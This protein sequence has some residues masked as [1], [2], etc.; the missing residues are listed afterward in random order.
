MRKFFKAAKTKVQNV[1]AKV[2]A[3]LAVAGVSVQ[4]QAAGGL[5]KVNT[6]LDNILGVLNGASIAVVTIA[7]IWAGYKFLF[8]NAEKEEI[9][10]IVS[11]GLLIGGAG[12][13][14][15]FLLG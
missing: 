1:S 5:E 9:I 15:V 12:Q 14:A 7:I 13:L 10:K 6:F 8:K 2:A 3:M 11:A 4:V